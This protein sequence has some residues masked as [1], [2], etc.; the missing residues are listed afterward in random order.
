METTIKNTTEQNDNDSNMNQNTPAPFNTD[1]WAID[2]DPLNNPTYPMK[3]TT[4]ADHQ[5]LNYERAPQQPVNVEVL[6]S[7]ERPAISRV[8]GT[9]TP[10]RG[11]SGMLRRYAYK[12]SEGQSARWFTLVLADKIDVAEGLVDDVRRGHLPNVLE[13]NGWRM[14]W[15]YNKTKLIRKAVVGIAVTSAIAAAMAWRWRRTASK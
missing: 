1:S 9:S 15:K 7:T 11:L 8:F 3:R 4:G 2:A 13:E 12:F 5:R 6:K 10:P 14:E